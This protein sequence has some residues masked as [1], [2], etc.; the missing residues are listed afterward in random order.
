MCFYSFFFNL[1]L[2]LY[3]L[4]VYVIFCA[5]W[6][7]THFCCLFIYFCFQ[8]NIPQPLNKT[9][10]IYLNT[11]GGWSSVYIYHAKRQMTIFVHLF[12]YLSTMPHFQLLH[13]DWVAI[14][15]MDSA[16]ISAEAFSVDFTGLAS[17]SF[18]LIHS[19]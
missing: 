8:V 15:M 19:G 14:R 7:I 18:P 11:G 16:C 3:S 5:V 4:V 13:F 6:F 9:Y 1:F 12:F 2:G 10:N 17:R